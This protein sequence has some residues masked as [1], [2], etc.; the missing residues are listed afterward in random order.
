MTHRLGLSAYL[1][2][3][4]AMVL[5]MPFTSLTGRH[6]IMLLVSLLTGAAVLRVIPRVPREDRTP[7]ILLATATG[8][9]V[10]NNLIA[11]GGDAVTR[12]L[13]LVVTISNG[14]MLAAAVALVL[15]RGR[16][17]VGGL[18]DGTVF[19]V[20]A[21]GLTW[22]AVLMPRLETEGVGRLSEMTMLAP[23]LLLA[24]VLGA[25]LRLVFLNRG[26]SVPLLFFSGAVLLELSGDV[27]T[28]IAT[29]SVGGQSTAWRQLFFVMAY[30]FLGLAV[31]HPDA[32]QLAAAG[33]APQDRLTTGRLVFLGSMVAAVPLMTALREMIGLAADVPL[34]LVGNL[35]VVPLVM[36]R[37]G[38]LARQRERAEQRL[39]HQATHDVLTGLPNRA[40]LWA[41][42]DAALS[43]EEAAGRPSVVLLFCDL[44][45]F[46][47]VNDRFGHLAGDRLLVEVATR[48]G[49]GLRSGDTLARYG[50][51]E[52]VLLCEEPAQAEA[53]E[54]LA[55]HVRTV[56][57]EPVLIDGEA[58]TVGASVGAVLSDGRRGAD[59]LIRSAD[60]AMYLEKEAL[61][62]ARRVAA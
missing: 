34:L 37:V 10:L 60:H 32:P 8:W 61:A 16:N 26:H 42:L 7:A 6:V 38:R 39:R 1:C 40:E 58:V 9:L 12:I 41:R 28:I 24:G 44:N 62:E 53:A 4:G 13:D 35:L 48:I 21:A 31:L 43:R 27:V 51:D 11:F 29:G 50:G 45:G 56:L 36:V 14:I 19:A 55:S 54:R 20:V 30:V 25:L 52:F 49:A 15:R 23:V 57:G 5:T 59:E 47:Q 17:D 33:P 2:A 22:T 3:T 46:K 18:L